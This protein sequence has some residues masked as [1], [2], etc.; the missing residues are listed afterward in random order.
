[1]AHKHPQKAA[2]EVTDD[3]RMRVTTL[4]AWGRSY[5]RIAAVLGITV[6]EL[7]RLY[8]YELT[9]CGDDAAWVARDRVNVI[10]ARQFLELFMDGNASA[11]CEL[12]AMMQVSDET[13]V[14]APKT[15]FGKKERAKIEARKPDRSSPLGELVARRDEQYVGFEL[16][17]LGKPDSKRPVAH[18]QS[19]VK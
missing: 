17:R 3:T 7:K 2:H 19:A 15:K 4:M 13:D 5:K 18:P 9:R 10:L 16:H 14:P 11:G 12:R 1:M 6:P 8:R